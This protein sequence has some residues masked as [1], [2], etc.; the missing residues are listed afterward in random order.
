MKT[1]AW[2]WQ[3]NADYPGPDPDDGNLP[4]G[5]AWV[6]TH[7]GAV[8]MDYFYDHALV[9][10]DANSVRRLKQVYED[11]GIGFVPWCVPKGLRPRSEERPVGK[12]CR[13]RWSPYPVKKDVRLL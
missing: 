11:Q 6:K 1:R 5:E 4:I 10:K 9:P 3:L 12:Q 8:W 2:I 13:S 7:D